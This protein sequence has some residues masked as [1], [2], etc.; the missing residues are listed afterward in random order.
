MHRTVRYLPLFVVCLAL[1][2]GHA[3]AQVL[4]LAPTGGDDTA[5]LQNAL[6]TCSRATTADCS[7]VLC[8]G[9]FQTGILRVE[10]FR[11]TLRGAGPLATTLRALP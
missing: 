6:A 5:R 8:A 2:A 1:F 11:G 10:D 3:A 7:V 9:V 4:C